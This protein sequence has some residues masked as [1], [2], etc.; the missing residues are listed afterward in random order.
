[1]RVYWRYSCDHGHHWHFFREEDSH[2]APEDAKCVEGHEA[3]TLSKCAPTPEV[4]I[5]VRPAAYVGDSVT[6]RLQLEGR[7]LIVLSDLRG[8]IEL[9]SIETF[10]WD[11]AV[12]YSRQFVGKTMEEVILR[13]KKMEATKKRRLFSRA[14]DRVD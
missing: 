5:T 1:M 6:G 9:V 13:V 2:E 3:V 4:Q 7:Y 8:I 11:E 10:G 14:G 12:K